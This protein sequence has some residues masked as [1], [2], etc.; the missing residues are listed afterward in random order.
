MLASDEE[1]KTLNQL[2]RIVIQQK[3]SVTQKLEEVE[4]DRE[5]NS[6]SSPRTGSANK[7]R[8]VARGRPSRGGPIGFRLSNTR[9]PMVSPNNAPSAAVPRAPTSNSQSNQNSPKHTDH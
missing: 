4:V 9:Q 3:L 5:R 8:A 6:L 7:D 2:L 1:K